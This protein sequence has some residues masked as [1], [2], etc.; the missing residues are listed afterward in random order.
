MMLAVGEQAGLMVEDDA[1]AARLVRENLAEIYEAEEY[2]LILLQC[3]TSEFFNSAEEGSMLTNAKNLKNQNATWKK[4]ADAAMSR[5]AKMHRTIDTGEATWLISTWG[6][7]HDFQAAAIA[8][9]VPVHVMTPLATE[10]SPS[11]PQPPTRP[12]PRRSRS[13]RTT[14]SRPRT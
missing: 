13:S 6:G 3:A 7:D 1:S 10:A 12:R 4:S 8:Y 9:G 2:R 11:G 5:R 14:T